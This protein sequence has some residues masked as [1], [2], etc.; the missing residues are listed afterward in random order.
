MVEAGSQT[1]E[2][3]K[4]AWASGSGW[5]ETVKACADALDH[6]PAG[7]NVGFLYVSDGLAADLS[8]ILTYLRGKT[9][10]EHWV[11]TVGF[12]VAA[13]RTE[14]HDQLA[15]TVLI[16]AL[17][18]NSF[19]V[20]PSVTADLPDGGFRDLLS[21]RDDWLGGAQAGLAVVHGDPR[22]HSLAEIVGGLA[23]TASPF[24]VGGLAASRDK[25]FP[26]IAD[27]VVD[28]GLSGILISSDVEV[29]TGLTQGCSPI[30]PVREI[31]EASDNVIMA[32]DGRPALEVFKEDIG[33]LLAQD[34][35]RVGGYIFVAFPLVESDAGGDYLVRNL[36]AIDQERGWI[37]VGEL[38]EPGRRLLFCRRDHAAAEQD[39][40]RLLADLKDRGGGEARAG[41]YFSCVGRGHSLFGANSEEM[42][43]IAEELGEIPVAGFFGNGEI[44][45]DRIYGYT[46]V[47][48]LF[49]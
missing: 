11:G 40:R 8:S 28:G 23:E 5:A 24:L 44:S 7:A 10:I 38:V 33:E 27:H 9:R 31:T 47:L 19:R 43:L 36:M 6:L 16:L 35:R 4:A 45:R 3:A 49:R 15:M 13:T 22:N 41:L 2:G 14:Y 46:G 21:L 34:L 30:G 32:I 18:E 1:G 20:F 25:S 42:K 12:G 29:I 48:A 37:S 26:Q 17:P 39:L